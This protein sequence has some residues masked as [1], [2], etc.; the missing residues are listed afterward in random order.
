M[1][2]LQQQHQQA[3]VHSLLEIKQAVQRP[4]LEVRYLA[5]LPQAQHQP[6][7]VLHRLPQQVEVYLAPKCLLPQV[8]LQLLLLLPVLALEHLPPLC[9]LH[10]S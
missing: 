8:L 4:V 10:L 1:H 9:Q 3:Q 6:L 5:K 7:V 2:R